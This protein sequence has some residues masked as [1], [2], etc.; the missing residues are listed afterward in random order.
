MDAVLR[1]ACWASCQAIVLAANTRDTLL[2]EGVVMQLSVTRDHKVKVR[3][4]I[5]L[6]VVGERVR[7]REGS[8]PVVLRRILTLS[9]RKPSL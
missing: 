9:S 5:R 7:V 3:K 8:T 6:I 4:A 2:R 1:M